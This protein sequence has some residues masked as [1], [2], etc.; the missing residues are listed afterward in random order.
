MAR[1]ARRTPGDSRVLGGTARLARRTL[2]VCSIL[3]G[4]ARVAWGRCRK[5]DDF[6]DRVRQFD[7]PE[8]FKACFRLAWALLC[9]RAHPNL[10]SNMQPWQLT[11]SSITRHA[12]FPSEAQRREAVR[13]VVRVCER[14]LVQFCIVDDHVHVVVL[15]DRARCGHMARGLK[16]A[17]APIAAVPINPVRIGTIHGRNHMTEIHRYV[18]QQPAHHD[19]SVHPA[20][21]SGSCFLDLV[22]ARWI[23]GLRLRLVDVLPRL[24][25]T[26]SLACVGLRGWTPA[27]AES[28]QVRSLGSRALVDAAAAACAAS[29]ELTS[30]CAEVSRARR[31][32]CVLARQAGVPISEMSWALGVHPG[33][34][35][36]LAGSD[37]EPQA[38]AAARTYLALEQAVRAAPPFRIPD[39]TGSGNRGH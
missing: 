32:A 30:R 5:F 28:T 15:C 2:G 16:L 27:P 29:P 1:L 19:L 24:S 31:V 17:L 8:R 11:T 39:K 38:L 14:E 21:W 34:A 6:D 4:T 26:D 37:V 7:D 20:L 25:V 3:G 18:L 9:A 12:L 33:S 22:G 13:A 36:K 23:P 10:E 35:R